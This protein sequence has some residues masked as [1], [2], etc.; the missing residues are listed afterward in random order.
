MRTLTETVYRQK[1]ASRRNKGDTGNTKQF[2][3]KS[4]RT[5]FTE[6]TTITL[7]IPICQG[8]FAF[9]T[10]KAFRMPLFTEAGYSSLFDNFIT[11]CTNI[12][13]HQTA[14]MWFSILLP[15]FIFQRLA[16]ARTHKAFR[17]PLFAKCSNAFVSQWFVASSTNVA[18]IRSRGRMEWRRCWW[19]C[20]RWRSFVL[21]ETSFTIG[22]LIP[23]KVILQWLFT[24]VAS[25][26]V[27]VIFLVRN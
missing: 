5:G 2:L 26:A 3:L 13:L 27:R 7:I 12:F 21:Q 24:A 23:F 6:G 20:R 4:C 16:A 9:W 8:H 19:L 22:F 1:F 17:M 10:Y 15:E 11:S 14:A 25:K 18:I